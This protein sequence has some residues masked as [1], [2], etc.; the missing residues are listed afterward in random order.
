M[1]WLALVLLLV[2]IY[3]VAKSAVV[4]KKQRKQRRLLEDRIK[5]IQL[6]QRFYQQ[7]L[8][9]QRQLVDQCQAKLA[10]QAAYIDKLTTRLEKLTYLCD[11]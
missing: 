1:K 2:V 3:L 6:E 8:E 4:R 10:D 5:L 7:H 9:I 11:N